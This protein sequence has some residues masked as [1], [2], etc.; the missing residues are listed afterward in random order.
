MNIGIVS[1]WFERGAAYVSRQ[2]AEALK[3]DDNNNVFIYARGGE[4]Y[5]KNNEQ[6]DKDN[7]TWGKQSKKYFYGVTSIDKPDF[8]KWIRKRNIE[9]VFFNEQNWWEPALWCKEMGIICGTYVDYYTETTLPFFSIYDFIICNTKRHYSLFKDI[10]Q[11]YYV[12]WGTDI[13]L[14]NFDNQESKNEED[15]VFFHS[16]GMNPIRKGTDSV[17]RA[18][19]NIYDKN[20]KLLIHTQEKLDSFFSK[21]LCYISDNNPNI[22]VVNKTIQAPGLYAKGDIY[23]YPSILDGLGLTVVEALSC[24][25]PCIVS[26]NEPMNEFITGNVNGKL[27]DIEYLYSRSDGYYWPQCKI[28]QKSLEENMSFYIQNKDKINEYK[29]EARTSAEKKYNWKDRYQT[30]C[31]IFKEVKAK[32]IDN[33]LKNKILNF[34]KNN[35]GKYNIVPY[36]FY[37]W[38]KW[39]TKII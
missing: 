11:A 6:W 1:T 4:S 23:V 14:F 8:V 36:A 9:I 7:V 2:Y 30:I 29:K 22:S 16:A 31:S 12:A 3:S 15:I 34:E 38:K 27:I 20:S 21:E 13:D 10:P 37:Y 19:D 32:S 25:L 35:N 39:K 18:F 26:N 28:S 24:G 5:A 33:N 17:L